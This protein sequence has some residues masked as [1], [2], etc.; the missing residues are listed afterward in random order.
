MPTKERD[1]MEPVTAIALSSKGCDLRPLARALKPRKGS[2]EWRPLKGDADRYRLRC[3]ECGNAAVDV[4]NEPCVRPR[5][6]RTA[7]KRRTVV[8]CLICTNVVQVIYGA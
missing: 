6:T 4:V 3:R 7:H 2:E 8:R 5:H 1:D